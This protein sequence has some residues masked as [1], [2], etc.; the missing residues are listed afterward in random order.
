MDRIYAWLASLPQGVQWKST[1]INV[2]GFKF[3]QDTHLIW[4]DGLEVVQD[5]F[6]NPNFAKY[7]TYNPHIVTCGMERE[8]SD[9]FMGTCAHTIQV[10]N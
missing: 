5:L 3:E 9:F 7:M 10:S 4:R 8:Y 2:K 1:K 6:S